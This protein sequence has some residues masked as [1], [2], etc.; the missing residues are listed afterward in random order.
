MDAVTATRPR[1]DHVESLRGYA[2]LA[3]V[4]F[5]VS[6]LTDHIGRGITGKLSAP[7]GT[8]GVSVFF[9]LSGFLLYR[10]LIAARRNGLPV[11]PLGEYFVRRARRI[12]PSYWVALTLLGLYPGIAGVFTGDFWRYY[13]LL[14]I[15]SEQTVGG[16]LSVAWT[17][18]VE[19][20]FYVLLPVWAACAARA[21]SERADVTAIV[22][23]GGASAIVQ[24]AAMQQSVGRLVA[25]SLAGQAVW[26]MIGML[27]AHASVG[28][29]RVIDRAARA[30]GPL[31]WLGAGLCLAG[32]AVLSDGAGYA[33]WLNTQAEPGPA[34]E[35]VLK[36][37]LIAG[38]CALAVIPAVFAAATRDLPRWIL[39]RPTA[40]RLGVISYGLFLYHLTVAQWLYW[41]DGGP[42]HFSASGL[43]LEDKL[44][45]GAT[46]SLFLLTMAVTLP[47]AWLNHR[48]VERR[49]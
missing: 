43:G 23:V 20:S 42:D 1:F 5:H 37:A 25:V 9:V 21:R 4:V 8:L 26:F 31:L 30:H 10:P 29:T 40:H 46:V 7:L 38:F 48:F 13:G 34:A 27:L 45:N 36:I 32:L 18:C 12:L 39:A 11:R 49:F 33:A 41:P 44:G 24:F 15:Y 35:S 14:Q 28:E 16:G 3:V 6:V 17:L 47:I 2:V 19:A 22:L